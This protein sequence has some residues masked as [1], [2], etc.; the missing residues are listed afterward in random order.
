MIILKHLVNKLSLIKKVPNIMVVAFYW[1]IHFV[2]DKTIL[3]EKDI[4]S[5]AGI[6]GK[7]AI[8]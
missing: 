4:I 1:F 3:A 2:F 6:G 7:R 5:T 8:K